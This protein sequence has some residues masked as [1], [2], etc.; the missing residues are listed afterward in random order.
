MKKPLTVP[1][2]VSE[3]SQTLL[4]KMLIPNEN[5]R[6]GWDELIKYV[7]SGEKSNFMLN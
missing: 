5:D 3:W 1:E 7:L 6:I 2:Y 4:E